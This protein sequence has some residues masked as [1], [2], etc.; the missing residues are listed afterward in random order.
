[1]DYGKGTEEDMVFVCRS[2]DSMKGNR[3]VG[4]SRSPG[5][6]LSCITSLSPIFVPFS[7]SSSSLPH[8]S[9]I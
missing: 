2:R 6:C 4:G 9:Y 3:K 5:N 8:P 1:M 7:I